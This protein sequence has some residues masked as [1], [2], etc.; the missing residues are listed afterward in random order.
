MKVVSSDQGQE[1]AL[2]RSVSSPGG[3]CWN[4]TVF[5]LLLRPS[6]C[7]RGPVTSGLPARSSK[8]SMTDESD[9]LLTIN[10]VDIEVS[11]GNTRL[12]Y[13]TLTSPFSFSPSLS[14]LLLKKKCCN[15]SWR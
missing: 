12:I 1:A 2:C 5:L 7:V 14:I 3:V 11:D 9:F 10:Y 8:L 4:L 15:R 13:F 6:V